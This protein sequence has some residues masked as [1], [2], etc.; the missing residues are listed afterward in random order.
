MPYPYLQEPRSLPGNINNNNWRN[1][2]V[3]AV[4]KSLD[5]VG[6]MSEDELIFFHTIFTRYAHMPEMRQTIE[7]TVQ[8]I[9]T[10]QVTIDDARACTVPQAAVNDLPQEQRRQLKAEG[11]E[12]RFV[13][14]EEAERLRQK[15]EAA[16]KKEQEIKEQDALKSMVDRGDGPKPVQ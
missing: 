15:M 9:L 2:D 16:K 11:W 14:G 7:K 3:A 4:Q 13:H 10:G 6:R 12:T 8:W 5:R 1:T